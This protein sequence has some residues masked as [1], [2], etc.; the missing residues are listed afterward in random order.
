MKAKGASVDCFSRE[1]RE[2]FA[3][4]GNELDRF[5]PFQEAAE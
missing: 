1:R 4:F 2:G 3:Q 5:T